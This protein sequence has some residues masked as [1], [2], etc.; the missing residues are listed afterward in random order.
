[1]VIDDMIEQ[2]KYTIVSSIYSN[3]PSVSEEIS[4][5]EIN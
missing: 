5:T 3:K 1:M 4:C 2:Y